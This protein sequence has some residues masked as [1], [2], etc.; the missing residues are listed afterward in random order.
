MAGMTWLE[1]VLV[2]A[3][4]AAC[5][6]TGAFSLMQRSSRICRE[7]AAFGLGAGNAHL[8]AAFTGGAAGIASAALF[9]YYHFFEPVEVTW[10]VWVGRMS[11]VL[12]IAASAGH[13]SQMGHVWGRIQAEERDLKGTA[14]RGPQRGTLFRRRRAAF[15][16]LVEAGL[17]GTDLKSRDDEAVVDLVGV[18]GDRVLVL[19]R[20]L[21]RIPFYGYLGTVAGILMMADELRQLDEAT[22]SFR[23]LR[24]M[25]DGLVLAFQTTLW[26]LLAYLPLRKAQD[27]LMVRIDRLERAWQAWG[28]ERSREMA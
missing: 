3:F 26:G 6:V 17:R 25:A 7:E 16:T 4:S 24:D 18:L 23:V 1:V 28:D 5:A 12:I 11:Y 19:Q 13:L 8:I 2:A 14:G 20:A 21:S 15:Q 27:G 22:E 9:V 10:V